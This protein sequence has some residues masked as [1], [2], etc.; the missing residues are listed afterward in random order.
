MRIILLGPPGSGKGTQ[1]SRLC[2]ELNISHISTG[3]ILR[4]EA[5]AGSNLGK[6][7]KSF[8]DK[9]ELVPDRLVTEIIRERLSQKEP[10]DFILDG[11][12]RNIAQAKALD[13]I[14]EQNNKP[15]DMAIYLD[16]SEATII[17]R[18]SGRRVCQKCG[19]N[20]HIINMPPKKDMLC[21]FCGSKLFKRKDDEADTI[22]KRLAVYLKETS[23]LIDYY[24]RQNK[25][26]KI[27]ADRQ[28]SLVYD[29]LLDLFDYLKVQ[30]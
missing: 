30:R 27:S 28:A 23:S 18:L 21:D 20:F 11:Y 1:A 15:M 25:L 10:N 17:Q 9:G 7:A 26:T 22:K 12:P 19:F 3:D 29:E 14:L 8:M 2:Q 4:D 6:E 13:E 16:T 5:K 24:T